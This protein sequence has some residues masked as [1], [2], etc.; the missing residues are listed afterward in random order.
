[1]EI[2]DEKLNKCVAALT[3]LNNSAENMLTTMADLVITL[4]GQLARIEI[5]TDVL[6]KIA[7]QPAAAPS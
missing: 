3:E 6:S 7:Q 5:V 2:T 1:M 4:Q